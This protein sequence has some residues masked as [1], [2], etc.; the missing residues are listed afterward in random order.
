MVLRYNVLFKNNG[1]SIDLNRHYKLFICALMSKDS[2]TL[3]F[4]FEEWACFA[5][6]QLPQKPDYG[7]LLKIL[8]DR[9]SFKM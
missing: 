9:I 1:T 4:V 2:L 3:I 5:M 6:M 7:R 8:I